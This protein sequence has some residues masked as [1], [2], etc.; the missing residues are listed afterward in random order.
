MFLTVCG[1]ARAE[2][3]LPVAAQA[4]PVVVSAEAAN[5]WQQGSYEVW[6]LRGNCRIV[7]GN[8][9][10]QCREAAVWVDQSGVASGQPSKVIAYLEGDVLLQLSRMGHPVRITDQT[11]FGRFQ[12]SGGVQVQ[13]GS[14]AGRPDVLPGIYQRGMERRDPASPDVLRRTEVKPVQFASP[15]IEQP[16]GQPLPTGTRRIRVFPRGDVAV[17][18]QWFPDPRANKWIAVIDQGVNLIV[19]GLPGFGAID[20]ST[21]R[22]VI[23]TSGTQEPDLTGRTPQDQ[24][25]PMEIYMEGN[26]VFRQGQ[27]VIYADR[28]Y[29]DVANHIGTVLGAELLSPVPQYEGLV[30]LRAE[31]LQ[32]T[33]R[34]S[35]FAQNA[36]FTSSRMGTPGY[37]LQSGDISFKDEQKPVVDPASGQQLAD[38]LTGEPM[39]E[40]D[41]LVVATNNFLFLENIPVFY[42]PMIATDLNE[43]SYFLRRIRFKHDNVFG[44][45]VLT[46]WNMY[47]LLGIRHP[48]TGTDWDLSLDYL[49]SRGLGHGMSYLY[50]RDELLGIPGP[51]AGMADYW[52]IFDNG[53][54]NLGIDRPHLKPD[55]DYRYRFLWQ[56]RQQLP[57]GFRIT[58][59]AGKISDPNFLQEYYQREWDQLKDQ[60]TDIELRRLNENTSWNVFAGVRLDDF[61]TETEWLPRADH[62]W[63]GKSLL[64]DSL[65]WYEHTSLGYGRFQNAQIPAATS[66]DRPGVLLPWEPASFDGERFVTRNELDYPFQVLGGKIVPYALG[67]FGHWGEALDGDQLNRGY[68]QAGVRATLPMW[69]ADPTVESSL[70][71]VHG[72]A[73][74][75]EFEMDLSHSQTNHNLN[76]LPLY[77]KLDDD[78][79]DAFR[80]RFFAYNYGGVNTPAYMKVDERYYALRTGLADWVTSPSMEIAG[81]LDALRFGVNQRWQTKRGMP[82]DRHIV[83]WIEFDTNTTFFPN[84]DRDNF[85]SVMG[86]LDYNFIWHVGDRVTL[87]SD[88]IFDFFEDGQ[89][90]VTVGGFLN[91]PPRGSFYAGARILEGPISAQIL[92]FSYSYWMSPK[93]ISS[94]GTTVDLADTKNWGQNLR[95]TRIGESLL[96]ALNLNFDPSRESFGAGISIEPRFLPKGRLGQVSGAHI[97]PAGAFGFE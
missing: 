65:T 57:E 88:G 91:R 59:E 32:Q 13:A 24:R 72:L 44:T 12:T 48:P 79:I 39:V 66:P 46:N 42:W 82:D 70:W 27:R 33:G 76:E 53:Y 61:F 21:D 90:I 47:Q 25:V 77:E 54:D 81:D 30:R 85:G 51:T 67:E 43:S 74:K 17:Q 80:R 15:R 73:H 10:I 58:A 22:L 35:F 83:D 8:D 45:Q 84:P 89:K 69:S 75:V 38:P 31:V 37:R 63:L 78:N 93:W 52:G 60:T 2:V 29:Y 41:R 19:N 5:R 56:H 28:M 18:A 86:L 62:F 55:V 14:V 16:V 4:N 87:L 7:Q 9:V 26:I 96:F 3:E 92:S 1:T 23:W 36:F 6:L 34:D 20:V 97:P 50:R 94:Y 71:N 40:H 95:I 68:Y 49:S 64:N 11:W